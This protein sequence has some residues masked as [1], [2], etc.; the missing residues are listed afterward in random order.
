MEEFKPVVF[1]VGEQ[2]FGVD[3]SLVQG[4]E[5]EQHIVPELQL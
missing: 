2:K 3:I 4:I 5:K 1:K